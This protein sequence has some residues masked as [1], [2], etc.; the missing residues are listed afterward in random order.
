MNHLALSKPGKVHLHHNYLVHL[1][2]LKRSLLFRT[3]LTN[4]L[5]SDPKENNQEINNVAKLLWRTIQLDS[6]VWWL[7]FQYVSTSQIK[8]HSECIMEER[9]STLRENQLSPTLSR[10]CG[11]FVVLPTMFHGNDLNTNTS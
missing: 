3:F 11:K 1:R 5:S 2:N 8:H 7:R 9:R 6:S 4:T 10:N